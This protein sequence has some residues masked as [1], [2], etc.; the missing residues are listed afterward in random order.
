M[1]WNNGT[2]HLDSKH[3]LDLHWKEGDIGGSNCTDSEI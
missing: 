2:N 1:A 3:K